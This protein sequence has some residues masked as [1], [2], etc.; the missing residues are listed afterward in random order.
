M[1]K[2]KMRDDPMIH[3]SLKTGVKNYDE[4]MSPVKWTVSP[5]STSARIL[6]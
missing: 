1:D 2:A 6:R 5:G 4:V 3:I